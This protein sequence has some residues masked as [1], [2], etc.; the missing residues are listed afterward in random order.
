MTELN[1]HERYKIISRVNWICTAID[2]LLSV[3]KL[4]IGVITRSPGLIADGLHSLSDL[5]TD[6]LALILGKLAQH[7]PDEDHPYGHAR[8]ETIGTAV[9]GSVLLV[10]ALGIG[11]ENLLAM[12]H[13]EYVKPS[14]IAL[15]TVGISVVSKELL[16]HYTMKWAKVTR[17]NLLEA[18][19]WHSRS[20]SLSSVA[21]FIGIIFSMLGFEFFEYIAALLVALLIGKMGASLAWNAVQDLIDRGV[22]AEQQQAYMDTLEDTTDIIGAHQMRTRLMGS[23]VIVDAHIQVNPKISISEAHQINDY[24]I[25]SLRKTHPEIKDVT[26]HIDFE[27]DNVNKETKLKPKRK[28]LEQKLTERGIES[29]ENLSIHYSNNEVMADL[30]YSDDAEEA[31][32]K[33]KCQS[34][35]EETSW[36]KSITIY[37]KV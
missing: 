30:H 11:F 5:A 23:D 7:G 28:E 34:V 33:D 26:L 12:L 14:M 36:L 16:F 27:E 29:F 13:G 22:P 19:A 24:A 15:I 17:S 1:N 4:S 25:S 3:L 37:R 9:L 32:L 31:D 6:V 10:I 21:V 8:Y 35:V 20:D 2:T 18:N